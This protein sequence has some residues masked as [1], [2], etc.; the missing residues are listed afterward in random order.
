MFFLS[1]AF[2][3]DGIADRGFVCF[4]KCVTGLLSLMHAILASRPV[5]ISY[6]K[7]GAFKYRF[8]PF[9]VVVGKENPCF[10]TIPIPGTRVLSQCCKR[11]LSDSRIHHYIFSVNIPHSIPGHDHAYTANRDILMIDTSPPTNIFAG[12]KSEYLN[13]ELPAGCSSNFP[14]PLAVSLSDGY[15]LFL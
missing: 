9:H 10:S 15:L 14:E 4:L 13:L 5:L 12:Q 6:I 11:L 8:T 3:G 7:C 2:P 1:E